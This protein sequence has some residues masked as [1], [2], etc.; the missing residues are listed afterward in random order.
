VNEATEVCKFSRNAF[1]AL[2]FCCSH[3]HI[4][5]IWYLIHKYSPLYVFVV[6]GWRNG[7]F[8]VTVKHYLLWHRTQNILTYC[9]VLS[10]GSHKSGLRP[11]SVS[12]PA[13]LS[14]GVKIPEH[15]MVHSSLL[16]LRLRICAGLEPYIFKGCCLSTGGKLSSCGLWHL[17]CLVLW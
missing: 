13:A 8:K 12:C 3:K 11:H 5:H 7:C 10:F 14:P 17:S 4:I 1:E 6:V 16:K 9:Y 2:L 15:E